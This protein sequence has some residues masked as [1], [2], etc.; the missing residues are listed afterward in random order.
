M[1]INRQL[2]NI[3]A[4]DSF[5]DILL[6]LEKLENVLMQHELRQ[7]YLFN[8]A[9]KVVTSKI[10][11]SVEQQYFKNPKFIEAFT[12]CF[13]QYYFRAVNETLQNTAN[14][15][16]AWAILNKT[17]AR[18]RTPEFIYLLLGANA[19]IN[20]DLPLALNELISSA[21]TTDLLDDVLKVDN[22]LM[23][24]GR[25]IIGLFKEQNKVLDYL[26]RTFIFL[27]YRPVMYLILFWRVRAWRSYK[28][29]KKDGLL[30]STYQ[31]G[32][33]RTAHR[34]QKLAGL[35]S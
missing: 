35:I 25:I 1:S 21:N 24:S 14:I 8:Q 28:S 5:A 22:L 27:Y 33:V 3:E 13:S 4:I 15:P 23:V 34:L 17:A 18:K 31:K 11:T 20:N 9:Y 30:H 10:K 7:F 16:P 19:H 12:V 2:I 26:K 32:S 6:A 29:I